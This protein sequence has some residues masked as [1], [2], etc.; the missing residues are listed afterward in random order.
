MLP[1]V[2][3]KGMTTEDVASLTASTRDK[4]IATLQEISS[5][6]QIRGEKA[7]VPEG[8]ADTP[9]ASSAGPDDRES[10]YGLRSRAGAKVVDAQEEL[11]K[12][13][14]AEE[15]GTQDG[16]RQDEEERNRDTGKED[17]SSRETTE[18]EMEGDV[19]LLKRPKGA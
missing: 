11:E 2:S 13:I 1:P 17:A 14:E 16:T 4:M 5:P 12:R 7:A 10:R 3:T 18:D 6:R 9:R 8:S 19:V 15:T